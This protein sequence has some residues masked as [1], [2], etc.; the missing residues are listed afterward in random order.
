MM[1]ITV[2]FVFGGIESSCMNPLLPTLTCSNQA[3]LLAGCNP[4]SSG[5]EGIYLLSISYT[6]EGTDIAVRSGYFG[7]CVQNGS[8][9]GWRC[10]NDHFALRAVMDVGRNDSLG[11]VALASHFK[12][13]VIF[14][15][16][17]CVTMICVTLTRLIATS[18]SAALHLV[19]Y[20]GQAS[21]HFLGGTRSMMRAWD[22]TS[23]SKCFQVGKCHW[24]A[25][26]HR[27]CQWH[28]SSCRRC[29][30]M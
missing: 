29:G 3:L 27:D 6:S 28:S 18:E 15:G 4:N 11:A 12:D 7:V 2:V 25:S 23:R 1:I 10:G 16:L 19:R 5:L 14:P 8:Q 30:N 24:C 21:Q 22:L 20:A 13:D 17:L 26:W 9:D